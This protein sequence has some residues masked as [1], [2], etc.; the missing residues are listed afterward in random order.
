MPYLTEQTKQIEEQHAEIESRRNLVT[1]TRARI[2]N[3]IYRQQEMFAILEKN[4]QK[5]HHHILMLNSQREQELKEW[6]LKLQEKRLNQ[7]KNLSIQKNLKDALPHALTMA[8]DELIKK[9]QN[10]TG[11]NFLHAV[12][13]NLNT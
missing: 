6:A 7:Q 2:E 3:Q 12:I 4:V 5:Q 11:K 10:E 8:H 13:N 9:Y 1:A